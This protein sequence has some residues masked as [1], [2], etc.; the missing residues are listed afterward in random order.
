MADGIWTYL[1]V[2]EGFSQGCPMSPV[3]TALVLGEILQEVDSH[4]RQKA[5]S[6]HSQGN[7]MDDHL[8]GVPSP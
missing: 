8:G 5:A 6:R 3:F 2:Q 1:L 4:F 7:H